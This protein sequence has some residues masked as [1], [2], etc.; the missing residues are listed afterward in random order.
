MNLPILSVII[1]IYNV[2][3]FIQR[4]ARSLF[5]QTANKLYIIEYI[6][7]NDSTPDDSEAILLETIKQY[8]KL[9]ERIKLIKHNKNKGLFLARRTG[10]MNAIGKYVIH[11]DSD[12]WLESTML[13]SMLTK[14]LEENADMCYCGAYHD[15]IDG[16]TRVNYIP[17]VDNGEDYIQ[18]MIRYP[19]L[20]NVWTKMFRLSIAKK[21]DCDLGEEIVTSGEDLRR[22]VA[23]LVYCRKVSGIEDN[24]YHYC[25][26]KNSITKSAKDYLPDMVANG[27]FLEEKLPNKYKAVILSYKRDTIFY[28]IA[29]NSEYVRSNAI[30]IWR[31][32]YNNLLFDKNLRLIQKLFLLLASKSF[33]MA[34]LIWIFSFSIYSRIKKFTH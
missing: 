7:V 21:A 18:V 27:K 30:M 28:A 6:F 24:L 19:H 23:N 11:I 14:T 13:E 20:W 8:P 17:K 31:E 29:K 22:N 32:A 1:P 2:E 4:C 9:A 33:K 10:L 34:Q 26:N 5:E 15:Y 16:T 3:Q 25:E 12:D